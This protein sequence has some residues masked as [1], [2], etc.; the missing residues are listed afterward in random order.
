MLV[1]FISQPQSKRRSLC[2]LPNNRPG[3]VA[4]HNRGDHFPGVRG[5]PLYCAM[6]LQLCMVLKL[7]QSPCRADAV[8]RLKNALEGVSLTVL[9][10]GWL[11]FFNGTYTT[12]FVRV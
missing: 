6:I 1:R 4:G 7:F 9:L 3:V 11:G 5:S 12:Q 2:Q 8:T 10:F